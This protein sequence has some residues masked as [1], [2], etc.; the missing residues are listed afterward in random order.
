M[1]IGITLFVI[2]ILIIAIWVIIEIKRFR[3]KLFAI[4]LIALILFVYISF[5]FTIRGQDVDF[6][7]FPG[8]MKATKLYFSWLGSAFGNLKSIT[9]NAVRMDWRV[10]ESVGG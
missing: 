8:L 2:A 7:T 3:H 10:N 9:T 6:K 1:V 4:F 5:T